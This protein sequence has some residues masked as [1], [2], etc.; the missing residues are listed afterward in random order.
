[1]LPWLNKLVAFYQFL[2]LL[3]NS[4]SIQV[5]FTSPSGHRN[6]FFVFQKKIKD[7]SAAISLLKSQRCYVHPS[8][9]TTLASSFQWFTYPVWGDITGS[10]WQA[11][12]KLFCPSHF[13]WRLAG[14]LA[15]MAN[16]TQH[17]SLK[18]ASSTTVT[19]RRH[20]FDA[21]FAAVSVWSGFFQKWLNAS[22]D[23]NYISVEKPTAFDSATG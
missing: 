9:E 11:S 19:N 6:G 21:I 18:K 16:P 7:N 8:E 3:R 1:M 4:K 10:K 12:N 13:T 5:P 15:W 23:R 17:A 22:D 14:T 20:R 2:L